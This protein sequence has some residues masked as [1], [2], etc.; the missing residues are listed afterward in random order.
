M[1]LTI[2]VPEGALCDWCPCLRNVFGKPRCNAFRHM[3]K[4]AGYFHDK[5]EKCPQCL[6]ACEREEAE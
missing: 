6:E 3:L 2:E 5:A 4:E 1:K